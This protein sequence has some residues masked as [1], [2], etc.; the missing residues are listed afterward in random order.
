M[1]FK[2]RFRAA[3]VKLETHYRRKQRGRDQRSA[4]KVLGAA[5]AA[6]AIMGVGSIALSEDGRVRMVSAVKPVA[7]WAGMARAR[8]PQAGD[9]WSG[10][11]DA[12]AAGTAPIYSN[13]PGYRESMD[14]D[15]DGIACEPY[16]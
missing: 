5:V 15:G 3:P 10:C 11:D 7:V 13:E 9:F 2:K 16:R 4:I 8:K 1:S 12:R 6:G 14:G